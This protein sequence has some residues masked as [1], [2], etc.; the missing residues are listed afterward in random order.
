VTLP[1]GRRVNTAVVAA[2]A[3][4]ARTAPQTRQTPTPQQTVPLGDLLDRPEV[5]KALQQSGWG[6]TRESQCARYEQALTRGAVGPS[7]WSMARSFGG[8]ERGKEVR[9]D[10]R[11]TRLPLRI[12]SLQWLC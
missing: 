3:E 7:R 10:P 9:Q 6:K 5:Q 8:E 12:L 4:A 1:D 2:L 11:H